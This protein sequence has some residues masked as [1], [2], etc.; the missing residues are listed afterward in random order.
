[1]SIQILCWIIAVILFVVSAFANP[2]RI[3]LLNLG[4][5]F[6]AL[7]FLVPALHT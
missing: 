2:P 1:M 3:A 6:F 7:G 5:A 4:L